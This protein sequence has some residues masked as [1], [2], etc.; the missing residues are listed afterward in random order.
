MNL[1]GPAIESMQGEDEAA[2]GDPSVVL[3]DVHFAYH[4]GTP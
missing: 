2:G 4:A 1:P 3:E